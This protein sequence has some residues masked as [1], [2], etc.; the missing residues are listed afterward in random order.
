MPWRRPSRAGPGAGF[1]TAEPWLP[2]VA[3]AEHL[4]VESQRHDPASTLA[5]VCALLRLRSREPTLQART[6]RLVGASPDIFCFERQLDQRFLIALN[7]S[8]R[9][10]PFGLRDGAG[11]DAVLELSTDPGRD[12]GPIDTQVL[13]PGPD[14]G[15]ILRLLQDRH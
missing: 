9:S 8:S 15:V 10:V 5:F 12:L 13:V 3:D 1:T 6:Q 14:E 4:C 11:G 2:I 7:Y